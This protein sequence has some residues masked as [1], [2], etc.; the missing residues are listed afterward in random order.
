[1]SRRTFDPDFRIGLHQKDLKL[2][3]EGARTPGLSL[4]DTAPARQILSV[5]VANG[6]AGL[7]HPALALVLKVYINQ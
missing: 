7:D 4:P 2:A 5:R 3:L 1:M 6:A